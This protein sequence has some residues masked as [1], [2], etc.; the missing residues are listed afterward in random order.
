MDARLLKV[1]RDL[2]ARQRH[3]PDARIVHFAREQRG[4]FAADLIGDA[5][6]SRALRHEMKLEV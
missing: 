1:R 2:H 3:E 6:G 5:V 4:Q